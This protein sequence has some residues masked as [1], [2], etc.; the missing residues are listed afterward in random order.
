MLA[1]SEDWSSDCRRDVPTFARI[2]ADTGMELR[3]FDRDG[4]RYSTAN[5]P[6]AAESPN[7]DLMSQFLNHKHGRPGSPSRSAHS[8]LPIFSTCTTSPSTRRSTT[9]TAW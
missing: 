2:A 5:V 4:Q 7:A 1:L 8:S 3:I 9:R 6:D